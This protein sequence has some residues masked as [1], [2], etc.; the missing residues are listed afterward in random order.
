MIGGETDQD[1]Q[2]YIQ[3]HDRAGFIEPRWNMMQHMMGGTKVGGEHE[4]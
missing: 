1:K 2:S 4:K 3:K